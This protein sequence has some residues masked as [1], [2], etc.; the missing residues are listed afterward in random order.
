MANY[1][2]VEPQY[3]DAHG[4]VAQAILPEGETPATETS[5]KDKASATAA[6]AKDQEEGI[7]RKFQK[8]RRKIE[9]SRSPAADRLGDAAS[10]LHARADKLPGVDTVS[11]WAHGTAD[12]IQATADYV[13]GHELRDMMADVK[14]FVRRHPGASLL[15]AAALG[16]FITR[17][18]RRDD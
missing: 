15:T 11:R 13:R 12:K 2:E 9:Q 4:I 7:G 18:F 3:Q 6:R 1:I 16:F 17:A 10:A 5:W 14:T 8:F